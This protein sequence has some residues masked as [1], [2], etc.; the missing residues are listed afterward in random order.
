MIDL[1]KQPFYLNEEQVQ[2]VKDT[3]D[4]L[5]TEQKAGQL[6]CIM[7]GDYTP[8]ERK[9][10][11]QEGRVGGILF[12]PA[13]AEDI[14][15]WYRPLDEAA[16]V[17]LLKAANLEEGGYGA[18][19][20]GTLFGWP[21]LTAATD[22]EKMVEKFAKVCASEGRSVGVNWTFSPVSDLDL[23][24]LN[25]ITN[26]R[27]Y[28]SD[29]ERVKKFTEVF[30]RTI[31]E[32][33]VAACAKHYPGDGVDYR[34]QHLHPTYNSLPAN[35]WY[36]SYGEI[37]QHMIAQD[38]LS[39]MVGHIAQPYV[40]QDVNPELSME[41]CL[42][43][44]M[45]RELLTGVLREKFGF[46]GL[47]ATDATIMGGYC[48]AMER[49]KAI[50]LSIMAGCDMLVF[51]TDFQ[52]DYNHVLHG[53]RDGLLTEERLE[54]AV[55]RVLALKAK[56]CRIKEEELEPVKVE[57]AKW[58]RECAE[59]SVTLVKQLQPETLPVTREKYDYIRLI[60]LG[61][62]QFPGGSITDT[63]LNF[64][65]DHG[66]EAEVYDPFSDELH[67][68]EELSKRRLTLYLANYEHASNQTTV[69]IHWCPKH[70]LD[71]PRFLNE[72]NCIFVSFSNPYHLQDVPR[73]KTYIN[74][75]TATRTTVEVVLEKLMGKSE[76]SGISPV[77]P[78]CG[79]VD[80]RL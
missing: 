21:M 11:V 78:F 26:V 56:A 63:A 71:S 51:S 77:D 37:Y 23:N 12:R 24:Y 13:P 36:E 42:P 29:K 72:E 65:K 15:S 64:L 14:R 61:K 58:H 34:D 30:I 60:V 25:P 74:A 5:T 75:Y 16:Q 48:M 70:A 41:E 45:S 27:T 50:P 69:R 7:G 68:T 9:A 52:E 39:I 79:L 43:A 35:E 33:G 19:S 59:K 6:F 8:E 38:L 66:F 3:L 76:F 53:L 54:E 20:D 49:K 80:T 10:L 55:T 28:G 1:T 17:P 73:I 40:A 47:I 2:W 62:D 4:R 22:D 18:I 32:R 31:Q 46:N 67:G 44:S 57:A